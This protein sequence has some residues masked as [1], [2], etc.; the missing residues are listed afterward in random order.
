M[1]ARFRLEWLHGFAVATVAVLA[2]AVAPAVA[3]EDLP[4]SITH[5]TQ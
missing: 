5:L 3:Q 4:V 2:G 1:A